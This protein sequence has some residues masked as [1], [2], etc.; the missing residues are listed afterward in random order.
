MR[1]ARPESSG[2]GPDFAR[3]LSPLGHAQARK[4][5]EGLRGADAP[6][7]VLSSPAVRCVQTAEGVLEGLGRALAIDVRDELGHDDATLLI[8]EIE[9]AGRVLVI[10]HEPT[11]RALGASLLGSKGPPLELRPAQ[12]A[13]LDGSPRAWRLRQILSSPS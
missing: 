4:V 6:D 7:R 11:L 9:S 3:E 8:G 10:T 12:V 13:V 5:G 1:H 2:I